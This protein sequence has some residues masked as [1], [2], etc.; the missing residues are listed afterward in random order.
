MTL[1]RKVVLS[2]LVL[3]ASMAGLGMKESA[4]AYSVNVSFQSTPAKYGDTLVPVLV[5][6]NNA[7][8]D[9]ISGYSL[10]ITSG[11]ATLIDFVDA[12]DTTGSLSSGFCMNSFI[13]VGDTVPYGDQITV[14]AHNVEQQCQGKYIYPQS[15][16]LVLSLFVKVAKDCDLMIDT[17]LVL[18]NAGVLS[19]ITDNH[20][21]A[22]PTQGVTSAETVNYVAG[23]VEVPGRLSRGDVNGSCSGFTP[24]APTL[25]DAIYL[26][27]YIFNKPNPPC[28]GG[29]INCWTP[30]PFDAG[31][32]NC[33][34][35]ITLSDVIHLINYIFNKPG[36]WT[37][38]QSE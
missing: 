18:I 24:C 35:T 4:E 7:G 15:N 11:N 36:N 2:L 19:N 14:A 8:F 34:N 23:Y 9:T 10:F 6:L 13:E 25:S 33:S 12:F 38:C 26:V 37:P 22:I 20:G 21:N 16:N 27:N 31:D 3:M 29:E 32:V 17:N 30:C 5:Y 1:A 28:P